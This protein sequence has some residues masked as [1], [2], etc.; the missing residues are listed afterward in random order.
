MPNLPEWPYPRLV[1]H[2]GGGSL[3]PE[4]TLN[5]MRCGSLHGFKMVEFDVK[6]T[7]DQHSIL[8]H[9]A[10]LERT[11]NG[12]GTAGDWTL[13]ELEKL[14]AGS[15]YSDAFAGEPIPT[16]TAIAQFTLAHGMDSNVEIKPTPGMESLTG[17][18]VARQALKD[19]AGSKSPP[20][21]SSF[22]VASL[23][24]AMIEAPELPRAYLIDVLPENWQD[25]LAELKC[26]SVHLKHT[27]VTH[28]VVRKVHDAGHRLAVWTVN[29]PV[30][31]QELL[32]WGVDAVITDA[33]DR[34][35]PV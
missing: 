31:A 25:I 4:N 21:L 35:S 19:W 30:R 27:S 3:A 6:L 18:L 17:A 7:A 8:L 13:S 15:W 28:A 11:T 9:D 1:A 10:T 2:R 34:I 32:S 33:I 16:L 26:V 29:D 24:A 20:L 14:D 12:A 5:A 23:K 22:S